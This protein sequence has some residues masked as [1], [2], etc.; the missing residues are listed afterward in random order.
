MNIN[1]ATSVQK[2]QTK[3]KQFSHSYSA[4]SCS[5]C[6]YRHNLIDIH[7]K[8]TG[9]IEWPWLVFISI[10]IKELFTLVQTS[11]RLQGSFLILLL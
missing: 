6:V 2:T 7:C 1:L 5:N 9:F 11:L 10:D 4:V 3:Q 8:S